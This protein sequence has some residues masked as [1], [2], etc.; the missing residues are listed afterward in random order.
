MNVVL[1]N[2]W[3]ELDPRW[4][5]F[6]TTAHPDPFLIHFVER[7]PFYQSYNNYQPYRQLFYQYLSNT[8]WKHAKPI[9]ESSRYFKKIKN[10][11]NKN[12]EADWIEK[13][14]NRGCF[15]GL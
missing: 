14:K 6:C 10:I 3:K 12:A 1:A 5:H 4:N 7:K 11:W 9:G 13:L 2:Q 8:A 15:F